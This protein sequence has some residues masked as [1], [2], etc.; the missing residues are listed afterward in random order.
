M[1]I[2][3]PFALATF[4][5]CLCGPALAGPDDFTTGPVI[6]GFGKTAPVESDQP[7]PADAQFRIAFDIAKQ[8]EAGEESRYFGSAAR[9]INMHGAA[10]LDPWQSKVALV[11]HGGASKDLLRG[12][13]YRAQLETENGSEALI[14]ALLA[15]GVDI[16]LCGQTAVYYD[17][18]KGDL[19]PGVKMA[20]SAMTAHALLQQD[21]YTLNPF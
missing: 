12:E 3:L 20:L 14:T 6:A 18:E 1:K 10:G 7:I 17:I 15:A 19:I 4:G 11:I 13:V 8:A 16:Y 5:F 2:F 9:L 21:G